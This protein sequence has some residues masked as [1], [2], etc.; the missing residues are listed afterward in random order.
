MNFSR[1]P[2]AGEIRIARPQDYAR[3]AELATQL[4]YPSSSEDVARRIRGME[5]SGEHAV[6][7]AQSHDGEIAGWAA[8]FVLRGAE[9]DARV[10]ISGL[11]VDERRRSAGI[12]ECLLERAG[13]W[14]REM[15]CGAIGLRS[16][17]IRTRAHAFYERHGYQHIKTQKT[18]LKIL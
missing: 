1:R 11:V 6:F 12:G 17:V 15:G 4:G 7:V 18:F 10:E 3:I 2:F 8:L 14:A 13:Q 5:R 9:M 16:N